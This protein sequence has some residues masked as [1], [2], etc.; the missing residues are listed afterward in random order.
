MQ[1]LGSATYCLTIMSET[2]LR[3]SPHSAG[4]IPMKGGR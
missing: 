3:D 2:A 1:A 4:T